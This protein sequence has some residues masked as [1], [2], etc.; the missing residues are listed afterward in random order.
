MRP[1]AVPVP[2]AVSDESIPTELLG[3]VSHALAGPLISARVAGESLARRHPADDDVRTVTAAVARASAILDALV[4]ITAAGRPP[5]VE[6]IPLDDALRTALR[7]VRG[8]GDEL[9]VEAGPLDRVRADESHLVA[10]LYELLANVAQHAGP[11]PR[12]QLRSQRVGDE[13]R[14]V[15]ADLGPG[16]PATLDRDKPRWFSRSDGSSTR[17]GSGIAV[18][19]ALAAADGG[20]LELRDGPMGGTE[21]NLWLPAA[22]D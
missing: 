3:A 15:I 12:A 5:F 6:D 4:R 7:R 21:A 2:R 9:E 22:E 18:A 17:A 13:V 1:V 16:L 14:L 11:G 8:A 19:V 10:I 20:H